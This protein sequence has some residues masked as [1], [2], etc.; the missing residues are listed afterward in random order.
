[1]GRTFF[2]TDLG[3]AGISTPSIQ[4][5]DSIRF[6]FKMIRA[7]VQRQVSPDELGVKTELAGKDVRFHRITAFAYVSCYSR[8]EFGRLEK[9][10]FPDWTQRLC[11]R[12]KVEKSYI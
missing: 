5:G 1:M 8:E 3:F 4:R 6:I 12:D 7:G 10:S 9:D 11:F 2:I